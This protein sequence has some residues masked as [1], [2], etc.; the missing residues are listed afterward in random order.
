M[1]KRKI[2]TPGR[3]HLY[4]LI[5]PGVF[6]ALLFVWPLATVVYQALFDP[7]FGLGNF[8]T[9]LGSTT[10]IRVLLFTFEL[11]G[12]VT[13]ICL[14]VAYPVAYLVSRARDSML[15][16]AL[17]LILI[18]FWTSVVIR[19]YA[20][21]ALFQ[22]YGL[23]NDLLLELGIVDEPVKFIYNDVGV[24]IGMVQI[25]LP[26]MILPLL[27][28][29][30][31]MDATLIRAA[32]ILGA[33]PLRVFLH[34]YLP[35]SMPGVTAGVLLVF[36]SAVGFYVTPAVLGG[37]RQMMVAVLIEQYVTRTLN[38]PLASALATILLA[39]TTVLYLVYERV[40]R[41]V[42]GAFNMGRG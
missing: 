3:G 40:T 15:H 11:A 18:P 23:V 41:R 12:E 35:L 1:R 10:H 26:F 28:T 24:L 31:R 36:I 21:A 25:L 7:S 32:E 9:I 8:A 13:L 30:R 37:P 19:T 42:G 27:N 22:R 39:I 14:L 34:V 4:L 33:N 5:P 6:I 20:W 16:I 17:A 2:W 29:M 38:W